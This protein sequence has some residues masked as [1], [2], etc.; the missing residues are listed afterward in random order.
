MRAQGQRQTDVHRTVI[1]QKWWLLSAGAGERGSG[2]PHQFP[3]GTG[4]PA[5][6]FEQGG[7]VEGL[8]AQ[9]RARISRMAG[10]D[11]RVE[12]ALGR[13]Q[14]SAFQDQAVVTIIEVGSLIK[15]L[16]HLLGLVPEDTILPSD[17]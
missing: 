6:G 9:E 2:E 14:T 15:S 12:L 5:A 17:F 13:D 7:K 11:F 8:P 16:F 4:C 1:V 3:F 10:Q